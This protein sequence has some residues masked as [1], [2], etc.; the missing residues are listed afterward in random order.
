MK[1]VEPLIALELP[2]EPHSAKVARDAIAGL[3]GH[4]GNVFG[5]VVLLISELVTNSVRHAGLDATQ[6]LQ[7]SVVTSGDTVRVAVRDPG[8]GFRP[9]PPPSDPGHV[10]GW[11]LVLVDQ[12]AEKWGVEHDGEANRGVVRAEE[13]MTFSAEVARRS[14]AAVVV[15]KGDLDIASEA[16]AT[17][18]LE[19]AMDGCGLLIADL[20][21]LAFLDS[22]GVRVLLSAH[23][24]AQERGLRFGVVRGDGMIARLLEVTRISDRF[25]VVDDPAELIDAG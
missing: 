5:D 10:G 15:M 1:K 18:E 9:P 23:L 19:R 2:A 4:L 16:R 22:T 24:Q 20:R 21:E 12:L 25:P 14:D 13:E 7:L 6:P 3:D 8:P 17:A 11:G